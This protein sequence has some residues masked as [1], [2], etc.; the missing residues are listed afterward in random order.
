MTIQEQHFDF[1]IK[2]DK[3]STE[4]RESFNVAHKDWLLNEAEQVLLNQRYGLNNNAK[5]GF[6]ATQKRIDDLSTLHIKYPNQPA[7]TPIQH[8][9]GVWEVP[10]S[11]LSFP[12]LHYTR[13]TVEVT[14]EG[15]DPREVTISIIQNDDIIK[16]LRDPFRGSG[17]SEVLGNFGKSSID[18]G[19]SLFL[20]SPASLTLDNV[21]LEYIKKPKR[22]NFGGYRYI[23]G[24]IYLTQ[25]SEFPEH[26][27]STIVDIAADIA[28]GIIENNNYSQLT[29]KKLFTKE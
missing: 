17:D 21:K 10:L 6:E 29:T 9:A 18:D 5:R 15:C 2:I 19:P 25:N 3:V 26:V 14:E 13:G 20:Y 23:D 11:S 4:F 22:V 12:Y 8:D 28:A 16:S 1:D 27:H 24:V 7:I